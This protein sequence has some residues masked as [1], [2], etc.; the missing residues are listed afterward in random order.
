[1]Y[2]SCIWVEGLSRTTKKKAYIVSG[3]EQG[4]LHVRRSAKLSADNVPLYSAFVSVSLLVALR[5]YFS[6]YIPSGSF[7]SG[8]ANF[9]FITI[10]KDVPFSRNPR[11]QTFDRSACNCESLVGPCCVLELHTQVHWFC[12]SY[13]WL[14]RSTVVE[15]K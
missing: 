4:T 13:L 3:L 5:T 11:L 8:I 1:M 14:S 15:L 2:S 12:A 7:M 10:S 6:T 9:Y